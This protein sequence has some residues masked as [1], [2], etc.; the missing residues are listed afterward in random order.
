MQT[1]EDDAMR[2]DEP[3]FA[4][5]IERGRDDAIHLRDE[6]EEVEELL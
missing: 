5:Q 4:N 1:Y 2:E 6:D 3:D